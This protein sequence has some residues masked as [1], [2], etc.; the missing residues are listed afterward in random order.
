[1]HLRRPIFSVVEGGSTCTNSVIEFMSVSVLLS[2]QGKP[3]GC[4]ALQG[5]VM[6]YCLLLHQFGSVQISWCSSSPG[7]IARWAF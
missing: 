2:Y 3:S 6:L 4:C 1:M 5:S 7:G